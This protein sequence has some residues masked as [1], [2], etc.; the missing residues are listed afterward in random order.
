M[1]ART[2]RDRSEGIKA[3]WNGE[4]L[5]FLCGH[6][7]ART[8]YIVRYVAS[9]SGLLHLIC[10]QCHRQGIWFTTRVTHVVDM[11]TGEEYS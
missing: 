10:G 11:K 7:G 3:Q 4:K 2:L 6:E 1:V 8:V 9:K 5:G